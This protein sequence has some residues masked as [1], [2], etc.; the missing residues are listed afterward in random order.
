[1]KWP[2]P[3]VYFLLNLDEIGKIPMVI[4]HFRK[5]KM[6]KNLTGKEQST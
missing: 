6:V 3:V 5:Y 4:R 1:M 2:V